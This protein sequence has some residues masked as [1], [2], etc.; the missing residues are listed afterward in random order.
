[1]LKEKTLA[2]DFAAQDQ[3]ENT[4]TLKMYEGQWLLLYFYPK[5]DTPGCVAEACSIAE[6]FPDFQKL[7][8]T[9]LGVSKDTV[10]SHQKFAQKYNL[11][12]PLL[13]DP[14]K[15]I[16]RAYKALGMKKMFG[17]EYEDVLRISYLIN[18]TG[19]IVKAY[20]KV[21]PLT[22]AQNVLATLASH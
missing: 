9:V 16:I 1:M 12:F 3:H 6:A 18:P 2:P 22:H 17:K 13:S 7:N 20:S 15:T 10:T 14:E 21:N 19:H 8:I 4:H 11:P 5:D